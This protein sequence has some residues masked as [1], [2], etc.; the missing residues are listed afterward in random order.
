MEIAIFGGTFDPPTLAHDR[1]IDGLSQDARIDEVWL[2]PSGQRIDK[3]GMTADSVRLEM[4]Q[5]LAAGH[6]NVRITPFEMNLPQPT[7]TMRTY[8][9][10][11]SEFPD[12]QFRYVFGAD[13]YHD[14]PGWNNGAFLQAHL[15][16]VLIERVGYQLPP[17]SERIWHV[18]VERIVEMGLSSTAVRLAMANGEDVSSMTTAEVEQVAYKHGLYRTDSAVS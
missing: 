18:T 17:A 10:L 7:E 9:A 4:L 12:Q 16:L 3:P 11:T 6:D 1:I 5:A 2:M 15:P 8:Q 13:S 14:M